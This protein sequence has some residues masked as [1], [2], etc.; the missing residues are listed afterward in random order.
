MVAKKVRGSYATLD[1]D[2][3]GLDFRAISNKLV[4]FGHE[5]GHSTVRNVLL[6]IY[7]KFAENYMI[8]QGI[9]GDPSEVAR[10]PEFQRSLAVLLHDMYAMGDYK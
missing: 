10:D 8:S 4:E 6:R 1:H 3:G 5:M 2:L 7:E 9:K